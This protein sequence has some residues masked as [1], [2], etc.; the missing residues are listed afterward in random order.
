MKKASPPPKKKKK[1]PQKGL[2]RSQKDPF[3]KE[4]PGVEPKRV[5]KKSKR[6]VFEGVARS[7]VPFCLNKKEPKR[8]EKKREDKNIR[9]RRSG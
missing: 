6:F 8:V 2:K 9:F 1:D 7:R 5:E 3:S 4:L